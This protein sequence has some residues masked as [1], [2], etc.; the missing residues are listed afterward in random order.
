MKISKEYTGAALVA[1]ELKKRIFQI[2]KSWMLR[3]SP[4]SSS[5]EIGLSN[6][7][8]D[9]PIAN[10]MPR[11]LFA[12]RQTKGIGQ[13]GRIWESPF[14]GVW[15]SAAIPCLDLKES[16]E[17]IGLAIALAISES[18]EIKKVPVKIKWPNDLIVNEKKLLG[19]LPRIIHRGNQPR[20]IKVGIGLNVFNRVPDGAI[21]LNQI[22]R[23]T[24]YSLPFW[25]AELLISLERALKLLS[26]PDKIIYEVERRLWSDKFY[27]SVNK[28][29]WKIKGINYDGSIILLREGE[30]KFLKRWS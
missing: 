9:T 15:V 4:V 2:E 8:R 29:L 19:F 16:P 26:S 27:D 13:H 10:E 11:A 6:W 3:W 5:T 21:S 23:I 30:E 20:L 24:K 17:L 18:L 14:G 22:I 1:R 25:S 12:S 7:L 28:N